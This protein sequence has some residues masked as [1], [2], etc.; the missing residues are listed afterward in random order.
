MKGILDSNTKKNLPRIHYKQKIIIMPGNSEG[1]SSKDV[2]IIKLSHPRRKIEVPYIIQDNQI[3][4]IN[5]AIERPSSWFVDDTVDDDG[6]LYIATPI[7]PLFILLQ[8][9]E[10]HRKQ[11]SKLSIVV[12]N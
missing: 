9:L 2:K 11:V 3:C 4:E 10:K 1:L 12:V 5:R 8:L 6:S 7:D